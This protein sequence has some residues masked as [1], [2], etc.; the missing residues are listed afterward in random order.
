MGSYGSS[1][2]FSLALGFGFCVVGFG[3]GTKEGL[4][5]TFGLLV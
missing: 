3:L 1:A 4:G 5:F 2:G